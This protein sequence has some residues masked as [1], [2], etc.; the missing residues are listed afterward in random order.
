MKAEHRIIR[1]ENALKILSMLTD[2]KKPWYDKAIAENAGVRF[3]QERKDEVIAYI[4][5]T[6]EHEEDEA[7]SWV[8]PYAAK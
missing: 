7:P 1:L 5:A 2:E 6:F 3:F 8:N 4:N